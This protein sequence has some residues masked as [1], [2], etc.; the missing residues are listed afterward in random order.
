MEPVPPRPASVQ[1]I[2]LPARPADAPTLLDRA[3]V[4][5]TVH[6]LAAGLLAGVCIPVGGAAGAIG[7][8][9][10]LLVLHRLPLSVLQ[11]H[12]AAQR[13][14]RA[15]YLAVH[16]RARWSEPTVTRSALI[17]HEAM[18]R[19]QLGER[20]LAKKLL[21]ECADRS[22]AVPHRAVCS[23]LRSHLYAG[24][25]DAEGALALQ[26]DTPVLEN[27]LEVAV[28]QRG[29][30]S[31]LLHWCGRDAEAAVELA[32]IRQLLARRENSLEVVH[33][34]GLAELERA[35]GASAAIPHFVRAIGMSL[36]RGIAPTGVLLDLVMARLESGAEPADCLE[37]LAE[38]DGR[39]IEIAPTGRAEYHY[40]RAICF[41]RL[42]QLADAH[43]EFRA[44][45]E[46]P[47]LP[48]LR[49]RID[50]LGSR[51]DPAGA[52]SPQR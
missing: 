41:E 31:W 52:A 51:L 34:I 5:K 11:A 21:A 42:D 35:G 16:L 15:A 30:R 19:L 2:R 44:A 37:Q 13:F 45:A 48:R 47:A 29:Q 4:S 50:A 46:L 28:A 20:E 7:L 32:V 40:L 8:V 43:A 17:L 26:G 38:L 36:S 27:N 22:T 12:V 3:L 25:G 10:G 23:V 33:L 39:Q 6:V 9:A 49:Q 18:C 24:E 14:G 1:L